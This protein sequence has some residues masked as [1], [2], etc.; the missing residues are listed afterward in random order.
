MKLETED[1]SRLVVI[2]EECGKLTTDSDGGELTRNIAVIKRR[3]Q[4]LANSL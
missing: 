2:D 1:S 3:R 4:T